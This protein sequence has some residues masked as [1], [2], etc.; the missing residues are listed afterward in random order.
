MGHEL[1]MFLSFSAEEHLSMLFDV[2]RS[3]DGRACFKTLFE[4]RKFEPGLTNIAIVDV[5]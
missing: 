1:E 2:C 4:V 5:A 3:E